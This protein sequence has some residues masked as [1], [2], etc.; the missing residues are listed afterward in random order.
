MNYA[1]GE[2][3]E[4]M[5]RLIYQYLCD[6]NL[7]KIACLS[8]CAPSKNDKDYLVEYFNY[9]CYCASSMMQLTQFLLKRYLLRL[10]KTPFDVVIDTPLSCLQ[11]RRYGYVCIEANDETSASEL[12]FNVSNNK[13]VFSMEYPIL[14]RIKGIEF[15]EQV[16]FPNNCLC[17]EKLDK[18]DVVFKII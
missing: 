8:T 16:Q 18:T 10:G 7:P 15:Q 6:Y 2:Q 13:S 4:K 3:Y 14:M 9:I 1:E 12:L 17:I 11:S 5:R